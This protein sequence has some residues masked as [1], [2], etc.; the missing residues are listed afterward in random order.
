MG[1]MQFRQK[2]DVIHISFRRV[3]LQEAIQRS[4]PSPGYVR[5]MERETPSG[6]TLPGIDAR[7]SVRSSRMAHARDFSDA[8]SSTPV[9]ALCA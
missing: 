3:P 1:T 7:K 8:N 9:R 5:G 2:V 6:N 4:P